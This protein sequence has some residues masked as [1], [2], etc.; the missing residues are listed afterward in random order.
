M[1]QIIIFLQDS[2]KEKT[3]TTF[4]LTTNDNLTDEVNDI[5]RNLYYKKKQRVFFRAENSNKF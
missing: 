4:K 3:K 2:S 5:G 1:F